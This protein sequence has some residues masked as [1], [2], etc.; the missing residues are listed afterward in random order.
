M[1]DE[2]SG[3]RNPKASPTSTQPSPDAA[4]RA[5]GVLLGGAKRFNA[6]GAGDPLLD[7]GT[8]LHFLEIDRLVILVAAVLE[9]IIVIR[10]DADADGMIVLR[11]VP[12]PA[13]FAFRLNNERGALVLARA[14]FGALP[15]GP[16]RGLLEFRIPFAQTEPA[17]NHRALAAGV[18]DH[19]GPHLAFRAVFLL[20]PNADRAV[21]LEQHLQHAHAFMHLDAVFAGVV[22]QHEIELAANHLPRLRRFMRFVIDEI[23]WLGQLAVLVDELDA[24][25]FDEGTGFH[26][27]EHVEPLENPIRLRNE[28]FADVKARKVFALEQLD[29]IALLSD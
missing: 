13:L 18:D 28:R 7:A 26:F 15:I 3:S 16:N 10:Y 29:A 4:L 5:I 20:K 17:H 9:Q 2:Y 12:E 25:F 8:A 11:D 24:V 22:E 19:I 6:L 21:A 14:A 23:K 1:P 27:V